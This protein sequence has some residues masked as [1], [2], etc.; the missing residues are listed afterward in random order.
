MNNLVCHNNKSNNDV[1]K[2]PLEFVD[3]LD[4][5]RKHIVLYYENEILGKYIQFKSSKLIIKW[6]MLYLLYLQ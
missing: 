1:F 3:L 5:K 2:N 4:K 6:R